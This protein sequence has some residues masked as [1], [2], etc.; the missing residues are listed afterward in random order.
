[1]KTEVSWKR[2]FLRKRFKYML[3][4]VFVVAVI[5]VIHQLFYFRELNRATMGKLISGSLR[6]AHRV[7]VG[8]RTSKWDEPQH[9]KLVRDKNGRTVSLRGTRDQDISKYLPDANGRFVCFVSKKEIDFLKINDDYCDCTVDGSDEPGT[10]ACNNGF[11]SC[12]TSSRKSAAKIPS[13]KVNDGVCDCCDGSDEWAEAV[14][15][16]EP[17][18]AGGVIFHAVKCP[19]RC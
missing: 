1:M 10:N 17:N 5:F 2:R 12:E 14:L 9:S 13:Y 3:L 16:R 19:N 7:I 15:L 4:C 8:K 11:F 6:D 18:E